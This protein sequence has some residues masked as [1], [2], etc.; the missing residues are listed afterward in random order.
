MDPSVLSPQ[1][2]L[3][4]DSSH[5][6]PENASVIPP[7]PLLP[8]PPAIARQLHVLNPIINGIRPPTN[9]KAVYKSTRRTGPKPMPLLKRKASWK[10]PEY[11]PKKTK[12][13]R[14]REKKLTVIM[15]WHYHRIEEW[16]RI[17]QRMVWRKPYYYEI[18]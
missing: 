13:F 1:L 2:N 16:D 11:V 6:L 8:L 3:Q 15:Y 18:K 10:K 9:A 4:S 12:Q 17:K 14:P 7:E 5:S